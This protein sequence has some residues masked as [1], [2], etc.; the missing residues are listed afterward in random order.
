VGRVYSSSFEGTPITTLETP[1]LYDKYDNEISLLQIFGSALLQV[2]VT[3]GNRLDTNFFNGCSGL[4]SIIVASKDDFVQFKFGCLADCTNLK[5]LTV[6]F[7]GDLAVSPNHTYIGYLFGYDSYIYNPN[8]PIEE[9]TI[10]D[11]K[12]GDY[13]LIGTNITK[14]ALENVTDIGEYAFSRCHGLEVF[15]GPSVKVIHGN[16]FELCEN[17]YEVSLGSNLKKIY[18]EAFKN[19]VKLYRVLFS[20]NTALD[21]IDSCAFEGTGFTSFLFPEC[22]EIG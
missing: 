21:F 6:P 4:E 2:T 17:L 16:A 5:K 9:I 20:T 14:V 8:V 15:E 18:G 1:I 22:K 13:A 11:T 10:S 7:I 3:G 12:V 19:C